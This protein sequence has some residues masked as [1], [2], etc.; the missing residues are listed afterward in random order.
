MPGKRNQGIEFKASKGPPEEG[1]TLAPGERSATRG[2]RNPGKAQPG[3]SAPAAKSKPRQGRQNWPHA[4]LYSFALPGLG[5]FLFPIIPG[6][7]FAHPGLMSQHPSRGA[8]FRRRFPLPSPGVRVS[9]AGFLD[10]FLD[11]FLDIPRHR[12]DYLIVIMFTIYELR[13]DGRIPR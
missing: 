7:R 10:S 4:N 2:K 12:S 9:D 8:R 1:K 13:P 5:L 6:F 11:K 3:G